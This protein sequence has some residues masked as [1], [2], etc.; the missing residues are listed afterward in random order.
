M[1]ADH[2]ADHYA[3]S[4]VVDAIVALA[5]AFD[6][7]PSEDRMNGTAITKNLR[8]VNI[9]QGLSGNVQF[10]ELGDRLDAQYL[11][12]HYK[13]SEDDGSYQWHIVGLTGTKSNTTE[14]YNDAVLCFPGSGCGLGL[15]AVPSD[16][17]KDI[18]ILWVVTLCLM[19]V[20]LIGFAV[21][22]WLSKRHNTE[23]ETRL[24]KIDGDLKSATKQEEDARKKKDRLIL[25]RASLETKPKTWTNTDKTL[26]PVDPSNEQYWNVAERLQAT[27]PDANISQLWRVQNT[28]LWAYYSFHK[29]RMA[30]HEVDANERDV[31][32]GTS[33]VD[34]AAIFMDRQDGF[35]MQV[36]RFALLL[37][38]LFIRNA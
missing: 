33:D 19:S 10:N 32:H 15:S 13:R 38:S 22:C 24:K 9:T 26:V 23:L 30:M 36:R 28:A 37:R 27:M 21:Y 6:A 29:S 20:L 3:L 12:K 7:T 31:W 2:Y 1:D 11:I 34:P 4:H 18:P 35:M 25:E 5:M 14:I 17:Y 8:D 16:S